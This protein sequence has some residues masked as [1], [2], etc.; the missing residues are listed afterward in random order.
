MRMSFIDM[1]EKQLK[2]VKFIVREVLSMVDGINTRLGNVEILLGIE[3]E[4]KTTKE[5]LT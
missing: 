2:G 3:T 5:E 4:K 1:S